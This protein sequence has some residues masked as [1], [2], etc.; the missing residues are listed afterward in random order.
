MAAGHCDRIVEQDLVG[1]VD[2]GRDRC[3][4]CQKARMEIRAVAE[5]GEDMLFV[6]ERC[7]SDPGHTF[8]AHVREGRRFAIHPQHHVMATDTGQRT[9]AFRH[10][11]GR[12]VRAA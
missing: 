3:T 2:L 12:V 10:L 9:A 4:N 1:D 7:L 11:G 5:V 6:G 8:R